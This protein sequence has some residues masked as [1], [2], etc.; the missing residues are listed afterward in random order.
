MEHE[1]DDDAP[2][3][4]AW[5]EAELAERREFW[6]ALRD[7]GATTPAEELES[8]WREIAGAEPTP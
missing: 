6:A 5:V 2:A 1:R 4:P 7:G 3:L 8:I